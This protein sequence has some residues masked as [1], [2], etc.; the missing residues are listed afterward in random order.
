RPTPGPIAQ[1]GA[2]PFA[3]QPRPPSTS[4]HIVCGSAQFPA[5]SHAG[6]HTCE[7][8]PLIHSAAAVQLSP[9]DLGGTIG[10][11]GTQAPFRHTPSSGHVS[12]DPQGALHTCSPATRRHSTR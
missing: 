6:T 2:L 5:P 8:S 3:T 1:L 7:H 10:V 12:P 4:A 9:S 11:T